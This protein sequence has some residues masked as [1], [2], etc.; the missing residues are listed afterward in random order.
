MFEVRRREKAPASLALR[1]SYSEPDV[2]AALEEDFYGK[3]YI[4]E[5]KG[6]LSLNVEHFIAHEEK[7][8]DLKYS[9]NNLFFACARCNNFKRHFYN[10]L[11]DCTDNRI[12]VCRLIKHVFPTTPFSGNVTIEAMATDNKTI[13]TTE[14]IRRV[15]NESNTGNKEI[16]VLT[17]RKKVFSQYNIFLTYLNTYLDEQTL[18]KDKELA[19][20]HMKHMMNPEQEY[21][22]FLRW[23]VIDSPKLNDLLKDVITF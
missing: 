9:W 21:S 5:T 2:I 15:F 23:A 14:L 7:N 8:D 6:L 10:E 11:L 1:K 17:L 19:I 12:N 16:T 4:C 13:K 18:P 3:C 22:A 20:E